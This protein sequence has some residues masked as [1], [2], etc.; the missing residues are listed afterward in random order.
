[1]TEIWPRISGC[2]CARMSRGFNGQDAA[3]DL[4]VVTKI[5]LGGGVSATLDASYYKGSG[6]RNG[7]ER[8][9]VAIENEQGG[10]KP[11][12]KYIVRRFMPVECTRLQGLPGWWC[13]GANGSDSAIYK[14]DGNAIAVPCVVY[15]LGKI[16]DELRKEEST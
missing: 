7:K 15:V 1:M 4:L 5:I 2:L 16:A 3:N 6:A 8:E 13:D 9:F 12:R 11:K 14:M 10:G